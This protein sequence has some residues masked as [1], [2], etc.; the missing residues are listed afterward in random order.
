MQVQKNIVGCV[1]A[2]T[3]ALSF[4]STARAVDNAAA[5][6][7]AYERAQAAEL[8]NRHLEAAKLY[9][10]ADRLAP[11]P[12]ALR[13]AI[14]MR[15]AAGQ[16]TIAA[17]HAETL[18]RRHPEDRDSRRV[19]EHVLME[20]QPKLSRVEI[21][22]G[23]PCRPMVDGKIVGLTPAK[24]HASYVRPGLHTITAAFSSGRAPLETIHVS[25]GQR[26]NLSF[27]APL[28]VER[29][30]PT[31]KKKVVK[32]EASSGLS[33]W[34]FAAS[35][36]VTAGLGAATIWS[37]LD[38]RSKEDEYDR[39]AADAQERYED[40]RSRVRRTNV[41]IGLTAAAA[42]ATATIAFFSDWSPRGGQERS[43][44]LAPVPN[45]GV[46]TSYSA[47]W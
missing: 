1:T 29:P 40:G 26:T 3:V 33:P 31:P 11:A 44:A 4:S 17:T 42:V 28:V 15:R 38:V 5:A 34:F 8:D 45:G 32:V 41:L 43:I 39:G 30:A 12:A 47:T 37:G 46:L 36:L 20:M 9:E 13:G 18:L 2:L 10:L 14:R 19:A 25:A 27:D 6:A 21:R 24:Q 35:A 23:A 22:C 16:H 7:A